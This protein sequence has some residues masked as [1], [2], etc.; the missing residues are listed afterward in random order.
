MCKTY[1]SNTPIKR[2][3]NVYYADNIVY[4]GRTTGLDQSYD[5]FLTAQQ[6]RQGECRLLVYLC[7]FTRTS[8]VHSMLD[9]REYRPWLFDGKFHYQMETIKSLTSLPS[10]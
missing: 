9:L 6:I 10:F 2:T 8:V 1:R 5:R 4:H 7:A 3:E